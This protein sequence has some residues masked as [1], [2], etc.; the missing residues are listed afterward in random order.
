M[1]VLVRHDG[2][3]MLKRKSFQYFGLIIPKNGEIEKD[4]NHRIREWWTKQ[5]SESSVVC[6]CRM[7]IKLRGQVFIK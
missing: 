7:P 6:D 5:S 3:E 2:Q 4:V 1:N